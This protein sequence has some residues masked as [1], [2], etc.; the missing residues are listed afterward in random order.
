LKFAE[1][2]ER[3]WFHIRALCSSCWRTSA[4]TGTSGRFRP[5]PWPPPA[6]G[7]S[8][9]LTR[10]PPTWLLSSS[11]IIFF[12][13]YEI[14]IKAKRG[15]KNKIW[16]R[17]CPEGD[18]VMLLHQERPVAVPVEGCAQAPPFLCPLHVLQQKFATCDFDGACAL[19]RPGDKKSEL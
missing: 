3:C 14:Y 17:R 11:G 1:D 5:P 9:T 2:M 12:F 18:R 19:A 10:L 15:L 6:T 16:S 4:S 13:F 7:A 8:P